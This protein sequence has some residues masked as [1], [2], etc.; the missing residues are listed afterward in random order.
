MAFTYPYETIIKPL[1]FGGV[2]LEIEQLLSLDK[3]IDGFFALYERTGKEEL[4]EDLCPYFGVPWPAGSALAERIAREAPR[5]KEKKI[6]ELACGLALPTLVLAKLGLGGVVATDL[7]PDVPEFFRRNLALNALS[8]EY[9]PLDWRQDR[10]H[11]DILLGSDLVYDRRQP[12]ALRAFLKE[13]TWSELWLADPGRPYW[14]G[15]VKSLCEINYAV[16]E[17]RIGT[18]QLIQVTPAATG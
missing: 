12:E 9:R 4:F 7:H 11:G 3:T 8:A 1:A 15:F 14:E 17:E 18:V 10:W 5:W 13:S 16:R 2:S 6:C